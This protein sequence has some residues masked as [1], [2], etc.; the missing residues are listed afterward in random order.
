M[1]GRAFLTKS[2]VLVTT[3][4]VSLGLSGCA[5]VVDPDYKSTFVTPELIKHFQAAVAENDLY[6]PHTYADGSA[7]GAGTLAA[8]FE[9]VRILEPDAQDMVTDRVRHGM[10]QAVTEAERKSVTHGAIARLLR[11]GTLYKAGTD[12]AELRAQAAKDYRVLQDRG[13]PADALEDCLLA[14]EAAIQIDGEGTLKLLPVPSNLPKG[15]EGD[16]LIYR[17]VATSYSSSQTDEWV[18]AA[19]ARNLDPMQDTADRSQP[20]ELRMWAL[21]SRD[22]LGIEMGLR[23]EADEPDYVEELVSCAGVKRLVSNSIPNPSNKDSL[24]CT[25]DGTFAYYMSRLWGTE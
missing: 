6:A 18:R 11:A 9:V 7:A 2:G 4:L 13:C 10:D 21:A 15:R 5:M 16:R 17:G 23:K 1:N 25:T 20:V 19:K 24:Q 8:S 22:I 3:V 14:G 12:V